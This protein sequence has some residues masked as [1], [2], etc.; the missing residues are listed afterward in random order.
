MN[1]YWTRYLRKQIFKVWGDGLIEY[2]V[3]GKE[4]GIETGTENLSGRIKVPG[5]I[6]RDPASGRDRVRSSLNTEFAGR[7]VE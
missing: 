4:I 7:P 2:I 5:G 3:G 6:P 1:P